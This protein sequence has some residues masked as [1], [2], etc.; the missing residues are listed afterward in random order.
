MKADGSN[1]PITVPSG[2]TV[3]RSWDITGSPAACS[4]SGS[5][6][7]GALIPPVT[8]SDTSPVLTGPFTATYTLTCD[9]VSDSVV[10]NVSAPGAPPPVT[11]VVVTFPN[12]ISASNFAE[13]INT[14]INFLFTIAV[15]VAP[16][17]LVIAGII[18]MTAAGDP[19]RVAT[20]R[21]MLLWTIVG[22]GIILI[23]KGLV[24][25]LKGILGLP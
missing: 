1:G 19:G 16:I 13:L 15:I 10:V 5:W 4:K 23:S 25:V 22:F 18:F 17:L 20:A 2:S 21:R 7:F 12:P 9:G 8:G 6:G 3:A 14:L 11:S 24:E